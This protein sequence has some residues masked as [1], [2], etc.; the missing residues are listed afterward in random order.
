MRLLSALP[1]VLTLALAACGEKNNASQQSSTIPDPIAKVTSGELR[2]AAMDGIVRFLGVPY[3]ASPVGGRRWMPPQ[4]VAPWDGTRNAVS[5][6]EACIQPQG[7]GGPG[8]N[9]ATGSEDCL[10]LNIWAPA[11]A[12]G[13]SL[14]VMVWLHGGAYVVGS[15]AVPMTQGTGFAKQGVI[16]VTINYRLGNLGFFAHPAIDTETPDGEHGDYAFMDQ[17]AALQWVRDNIAAFGGDPNNVTLFGQSAGGGSV[18]FLLTMP[19]TKGLYQRVIIESGSIRS[20]PRPIKDAPAGEK[21]AEERGVALA[22][23]LGLENPT[24]ADLRG[25]PADRLVAGEANP[26]QFMPGPIADGALVSGPTYQELAAGNFNHVPAMLGSNSFEISIMRG[27]ENSIPTAL[28]DKLSQALR[29]YD[30][31]GTLDRKEQLQQI[32]GDIFVVQGAR[33][34]AESLGKAGVPTYLYNFDYVASFQRDTMPGTGHIFEIPFVF[35]TVGEWSPMATDEDKAYARK[36]SPYWVA[37]AKTGDPNGEDR[38]A[39]PQYES[40]TK[41]LMYFG[42]KGPEAKKNFEGDRLDFLDGLGLTMIGGI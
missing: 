1:I 25:L 11:D 19:S 4:P 28:G 16:L 37:F 41:T 22:A 34:Y 14:P 5:Y 17:R 26:G 27:A 29:L 9:T 15:G 42:P 32:A 36:V 6:G 33:Q 24:P 7:F 30:G 3:A 18:G 21:S 35:D 31:Y 10:Y 12:Q 38:P 8:T 20:A 40:A 13:A 2:G 39:W 23:A